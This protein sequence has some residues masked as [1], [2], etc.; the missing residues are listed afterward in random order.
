MYTK[1]ERIAWRILVIAFAV[2][3]LIIGSLAYG[4]YWFVFQSTVTMPVQ[5]NVARG[6]VRVISP[7][8][9][10]PI[11]VT[12]TRDD[13]PEEVEI[14][15]DPTSQAVMSFIDPLTEESIA[16]L[17]VF[18]D[19]TV[20][21]SLTSAP[22]FNVNRN[23][24]QIQVECDEG[25]AEVLLFEQSQRTSEFAFITPHS[26]VRSS[27]A[28][29]YYVS[30]SGANTV[31]TNR[32]GS[33]LVVER[34]SGHHVELEAESTTR[35]FESDSDLDDTTSEHSMSV[36]HVFQ[37][38]Y[39][40]TW[41]LYNDE[42]PSGSAYNETINGRRVIVLDR[43]QQHWP[44]V[45]LGHGETGLIQEIGNPIGSS[46]GLE[47]RA[48]FLIEEQSLSTC[49]FLGSECPMMVLL[50]YTSRD[51]SLREM[52]HGFFANHDP[53]LGWPGSCDSCRMEHERVNA[54]SW[55]TYESGNLLT[56][57]PPGQRPV[58]INEIS[59]YASGHAYRVFVSEIGIYISD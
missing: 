17:V 10:E 2:F 51:G 58:M 43:S 50:K 37:E 12:D 27:Q 40:E 19:S 1:P 18:R 34:D 7:N 44:G 13:L 22:R 52:R 9:S 48:T 25:R 53:E 14:V 59:F 56:L 36:N 16:S 11:A 3:L 4:T 42:E 29:R 33:V 24:Y 23:S 38:S 45:A 5:L 57:L 6:T 49:G 28:G 41:T 32:E 55:Y 35:V 54:N 30:V 21:V 31:V 46:S 39:D 47:I 15:T 26:F 20:R 8:T